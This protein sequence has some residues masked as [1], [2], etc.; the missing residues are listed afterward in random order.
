MEQER[1]I[2][3]HR[4]V[5]YGQLPEDINIRTL[6]PFDTLMSINKNGDT[7]FHIAARHGHLHLLKRLHN[8]YDIPLQHT[9]AD[10]KNALHEAAQ[11]GHQDCVNWLVCAGCQV[12]SLKRADW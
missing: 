6:S 3:L 2:L 1:V 8:E 11:N 7:S 9:N 12:D 4:E 5:Q 10:G